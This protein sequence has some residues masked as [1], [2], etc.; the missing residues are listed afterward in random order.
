M[1]NSPSPRRG[2]TTTDDDFKYTLISPN[3][4]VAQ[5]EARSLHQTRSFTSLK[6]SKNAETNMSSGQH[7]KFPQAVDRPILGQARRRSTLRWTGASPEMKQKKLEDVARERMVDSWFSLHVRDVS[8]PVYISEVMERSM[9]PSY[10]YFDLGISGPQVARASEIW[11][12]LWAKTDKLNDFIL[13]IELEVCLRSLQFIGKSLDNFHQPLPSNCILLHFEDGI[14]TSFMD[15]A[16]QEQPIAPLSKGIARLGATKLDRTSSYDALMQL[17]NVDDCIQDALATRAKLEVQITGLLSR[18]RGSFET[19]DKSRQSQDRLNATRAAASNEQRQL[20]VL[21][22]RRDDILASIK[23]RSDAIQSGQLG[24]GTNKSV[25]DDLRKAVHE[26]KTHSRKT[27]EEWSAQVR[28]VCDDLELIY[29]IEP[30][31][32]RPLQ[33][34][35]RNI[36]LP[37]SVFDDTNRDEIAAALGFTSMLT[38]MLSLYLFTPLPY[39]IVPN[40]STSTIEDPISV[41]ITQRVFPLY[42]IN[43]SY[44]FEYAVFLLNKDIEFLMNKNGLRNL[45][46]RHTLPNLKYLLYVLTAGIGEVPARKAGGI[47]ALEQ[48]QVSPAIS[49]KGSEDSIHSAVGFNI[50]LLNGQAWHG[51]QPIQA[52]GKEKSTADMKGRVLPSASGKAHVHQNSSPREAF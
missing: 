1:T 29:P 8:E 32:G 24:Q 17:A 39:P 38:Q 46:I 13:L 27:L 14:Y 42:P 35:I 6:S 40:S 37:N 31:K 51:R 22:R 5:K 41:A 20:R 50:N 36:Y 3:K 30:I 18:N 10:R 47:R 4:L 28:R 43:V 26:S 7:D 12:K 9:N 33:F 23:L 21:K 2:K 44:K 49:R 52:N 25:I 48:G 16:I 19:L 34:R 45:D 11:L 15:T